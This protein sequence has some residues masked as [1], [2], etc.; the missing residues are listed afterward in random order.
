MELYDEM[1]EMSGNEPCTDRVEEAFGKY[2][3]AVDSKWVESIVQ[4]AQK[5]SLSLHNK[6]TLQS[7][8]SCIDL[9]TLKPTDNE[10]T[11]LE[12]VEKLNKKEIDHPDVTS[13]ASICTWPK[14]AKL[15]SN[16]LE[17][18]NVKT[19]CVAG[20]FP[21]SQ[22]FIEV[23]IAETA[24]AVHDGADEIDVV[25]NA[26]QIL[27]GDYDSLAREIDELKS[28]CKDKTLKVILETGALKTLENVK[29]AAIL[30][31]YSGADFIKTSTGKEV[32][33]ADPYSFCV[34]C[35]SVRE[36]ADET[37]RKVGIKAAGGISTPEQALT[38]WSIVKNVL[39]I[40]WLNNRLFRIGASRLADNILK[41]IID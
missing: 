11:V 17:V 41:E 18:E 37:G 12:F 22:T 36:Y 9:T 29:K 38:Y 24:L 23:K 7:L 32:E 31:M 27:N 25:Q 3:M 30:A 6:E 2:N 1:E 26:G 39:G 33:G 5:E 16:S 20:G 13:V 14:Y 34:M 21:T 4:K 15:V 40:E 28:V 8:Y 10:D 35:K 19:C